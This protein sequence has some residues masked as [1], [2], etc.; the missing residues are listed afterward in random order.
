MFV[1]CLL[2]QVQHD[3]IVVLCQNRGKYHYFPRL[4]IKT[5]DKQVSFT[6]NDKSFS[7]GNK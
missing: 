3:F 6:Y 1:L 2:M 5:L 7:N 4:Y